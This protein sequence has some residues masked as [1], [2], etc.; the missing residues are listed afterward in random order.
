MIW[1]FAVVLALHNRAGQCGRYVGDARAA[2]AA[3]RHL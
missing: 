3:F 2:M 1:I